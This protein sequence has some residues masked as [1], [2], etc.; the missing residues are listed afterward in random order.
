LSIAVVIT[1]KIFNPSG[2]GKSVGMA[3]WIIF[4]DELLA[5]SST[6]LVTTLSAKMT[7]FQGFLA[8]LVAWL[9]SF[10]AFSLVHVSSWTFEVNVDGACCTWCTTLASTMVSTAQ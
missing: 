2:T 5:F 3:T 10:R 8:F 7:T 6:G 4:C 1:G 9:K